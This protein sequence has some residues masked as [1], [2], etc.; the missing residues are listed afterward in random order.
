MLTHINRVTLQHFLT[1]YYEQWPT[2]E[3]RMRDERLGTINRV[4]IDK[5]V[6]GAKY[7]A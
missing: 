1:F 2:I 5:K 6:A 4:K 3:K 7:L